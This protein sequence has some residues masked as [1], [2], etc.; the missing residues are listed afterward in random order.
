MGKKTP[1]L[2]T[3]IVSLRDLYSKHASLRGD[4]VVF[5]YYAKD[6]NIDTLTYSQYKTKTDRIAAGL[7]AVD[8]AGKRVAIIGETSPEWFC[9]YLA[10][11]SSGGVIIPLDKELVVDEIGGFL[12][13]SKAEALVFSRFFN[14]KFEAIS[15]DA[16]SIKFIPMDPD[17]SCRH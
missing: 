1:R 11:V 6:G 7:D 13:S 16:E 5:R 2:F 8:L 12:K 3:P 4:K 17:T 9:T 10:V 14:K 15:K